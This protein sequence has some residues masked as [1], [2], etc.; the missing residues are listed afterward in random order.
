V[1]KVWTSAAVD[2]AV[3]VDVGGEEAVLP[4]DEEGLDVGAVDAAVLVVI[5]G[6]PSDR[7]MFTVQLRIARHLSG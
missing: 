2:P 3:L 5:G 1:K 4:I 6:A 7:K